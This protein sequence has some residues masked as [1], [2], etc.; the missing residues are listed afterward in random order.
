[1]SQIEF[2]VTRKDK[3]GN[4][5]S[6][7]YVDSKL[8][9]QNILSNFRLGIDQRAIH[10]INEVFDIEGVKDVKG[11]NLDSFNKNLTYLLTLFNVYPGFAKTYKHSYKELKHIL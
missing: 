11:E 9:K 4:V 2:L 1:M 6:S 3:N 7:M 10:A 5:Y 8:Q